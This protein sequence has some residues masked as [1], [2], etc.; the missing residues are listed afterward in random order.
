MFKAIAGAA[1]ATGF[2]VG[3]EGHERGNCT[4][5]L[6]EFRP[7]AGLGHVDSQHKLGSMYPRGEGV[8]QDHVNAH[9]WLRFANM[10]GHE[11][12]KALLDTLKEEMAPEQ[13]SEAKGR[14]P[15]LSPHMTDVCTHPDF[16]LSWL[17]G[18]RSLGISVRNPRTAT[19]ERNEK[20]HQGQRSVV[21]AKTVKRTL[22]PAFQNPDRPVQCV[23]FSIGPAVMLRSRL[24]PSDI[25]RASTNLVQ[26]C[27]QVPFRPTGPGSESNLVAEIVMGRA[28]AVMR[29]T[30]IQGSRI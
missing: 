14:I 26:A 7:L 27:V 2:E 5:A 18:G 28:I 29:R 19:C 6:R 4:A 8:P 17:C 1:S 21:H 24:I 9:V 10:Q 15:W 23:R 20:A 11:K 30:G 22:S 3:R 25:A 16:R 12:A 13:V